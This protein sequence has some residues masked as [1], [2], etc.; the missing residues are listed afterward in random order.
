[1]N[2]LGKTK[3]NTEDVTDVLVGT[4]AGE[5]SFPSD[6]WQKNKQLASLCTGWLAVCYTK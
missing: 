4:T 2:H 3:S 1:M 5:E 6:I